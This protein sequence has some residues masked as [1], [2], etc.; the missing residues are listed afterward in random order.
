MTF[1]RLPENLK[2]EVRNMVYQQGIP[3]QQA[4]LIVQKKIRQQIITIS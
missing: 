3:F 2:Q 4:M 1:N